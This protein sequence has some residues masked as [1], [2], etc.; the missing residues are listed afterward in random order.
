MGHVD[1]TTILHRSGNMKGNHTGNWW[2]TDAPTSIER[3]RREKALPVRWPDGAESTQN[4]G[5][6]A[7]FDQKMPAYR[8]FAASQRDLDG[9]VYRGGGN[10]TYVPDGYKHANVIKSWTLAP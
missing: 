6:T 1:E 8:G 7:Q 2:S 5:F 4:S 3:V 9:T 10:Q